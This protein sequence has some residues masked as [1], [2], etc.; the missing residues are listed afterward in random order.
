MSV[1]EARARGVAPMAKMLGYSGVA[2]SPEWFTIA[3]AQ[4]IRQVLKETDISLDQI[5]LFEI[6]ESF[7]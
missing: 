6:N 7:S 5:D 2:L 3:P 4:A 1:S